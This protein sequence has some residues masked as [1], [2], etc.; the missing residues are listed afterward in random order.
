[1]A[2][3]ILQGIEP[4]IVAV[5]VVD[6]GYVEFEFI[7]NK[8]YLKEKSFTRGVNCTS[9]DAAM[10][11]STSDGKRILFL[12]EWKYTE[13]YH[14]ENLYKKERS[15]VYDS[16]IDSNDSPFL[17][18]Q[19]ESFYFE[20]FYQMMRQTLLGHCC[21]KNNDHNCTDYRIVHI[22][23]EKN[24]ELLG[25]ITSPYLSGQNIDDAWLRTLKRPDTYIFK[26]PEELLEPIKKCYDVSSLAS[27][28]RERYWS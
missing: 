27:Y 12:I 9:V 24:K 16:L 13:E 14:K 4:E 5:E 21:S 1:M 3:G 26:S 23:P 6:T 20:P 15:M 10:I 2:L 8:Q 18:I 22:V 28:L 7:G 19:A 25:R 11:G 17:N